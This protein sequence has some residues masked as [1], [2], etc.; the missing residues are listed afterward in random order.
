MPVAET[1]TFP[2]SVLFANIAV[3]CFPRTAPLTVIDRLPTP[4]VSARI[5]PAEPVTAFAVIVSVV[6]L[7]VVCLANIP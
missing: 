2:L 6:P 5:P 3:S 1:V 7:A 4:A